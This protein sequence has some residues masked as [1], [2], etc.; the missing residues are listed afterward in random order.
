VPST[1]SASE[2]LVLLH[3]DEAVPDHLGT[4]GRLVHSASSRLY[5]LDLTPGQEPA[6]LMDEP[7][8][9]DLRRPSP[10]LGRPFRL[11]STTDQPSVDEQP[12][13]VVELSNH[14]VGRMLAGPMDA[15]RQDRGVVGTL[16]R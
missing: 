12:L 3:P 14:V 2:I 13:R 16:R 10:S 5:V 8:G 15:C 11:A 4:Y 7:A 1:E 9:F 6:A